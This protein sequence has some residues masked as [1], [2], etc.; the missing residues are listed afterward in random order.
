MIN[1]NDLP[2]DIKSMIYKVNQ[3]AER[4]EAHKKM[5]LKKTFQKSLNQ[6]NFNHPDGEWFWD[7]RD[8]RKLLYIPENRCLHSSTAIL[9]E[10]YRISSRRRRLRRL[11]LRVSQS[12]VTTNLNQL[13]RHRHAAAAAA[14]STAACRSLAR[15]VCPYAPPR[16]H[17][18]HQAE[19]SPALLER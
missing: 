15:R 12:G 10:T 2:G 16:S 11:R 17:G 4:D 9:S 5:T 6:L 13:P 19:V 1:F 14:P 18:T 7:R 3:E 8:Q